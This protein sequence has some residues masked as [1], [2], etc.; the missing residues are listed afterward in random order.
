MLNRILKHRFQAK[1]ILGLS[2][3]VLLFLLKTLMRWRRRRAKRTSIDLHEKKLAKSI[4]ADLE[5]ETNFA[6]KVAYLKLRHE[7]TKMEQDQLYFDTNFDQHMKM[8][9]KFKEQVVNSIVIKRGLSLDN[10]EGLLLKCKE[11]K[12]LYDE[13]VLFPFV[14]IVKE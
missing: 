12:S 13:K 11:I 4:I 6:C 14:G 9:A 7:M 8:Y 5:L 10:W 1:I 3:A 2:I